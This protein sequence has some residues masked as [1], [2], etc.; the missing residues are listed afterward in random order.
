VPAIYRRW[1]RREALIEDAAFGHVYPFDRVHPV[2]LPAPTDD[3]RADLR[4]WVETFLTVLADPVIR[5]A[6]PGLLQAWQ[7]E[8]RLYKEFVLRNERDVRSLFTERLATDGVAQ[9]AQAAFDFLVRT[10][11]IQAVVL[12]MDN[13]AEY[14]QRTAD[15][16]AALV[17]SSHHTGER[18]GSTSGLPGAV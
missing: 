10:T 12:G 15:A 11:M 8:G 16:L 5:A 1:P 17:Y 6:V 3:L 14:C 4:A 18:D 7:Q 13:S 9:H 2:P